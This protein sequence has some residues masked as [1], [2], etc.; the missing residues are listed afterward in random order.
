MAAR[1][2]AQQ[3]HQLQITPEQ[4]LLDPTA[5]DEFIRAHGTQFVHYRALRCPIGSVDR[6]DIRE[7]HE[8]HDDCSGGFI[9]KA[10]G[11][12]TSSFGGNSTQRDLE[13]IGSLDGSSV[14]I[15]VPRFYD[16]DPETVDPEI[17][18]HL[19]ES[20]RLYLK[21]PIAE[22]VMP[23]EGIE[24]HQTGIDRL[25]YPATAIELLVDANGIEYQEGQ[26]FELDSSNGSLRWLGSRRPGYDPERQR[27]T[28]FQVR[29]RYVP[30]W[31]VAKLMHEIRVTKA[32]SDYVT[33]KLKLYRMNYYALLQREKVYDV[34]N[35]PDLEILSDIR[36]I[37]GARDGSF[38]PR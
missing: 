19:A 4:E 30:F 15:T 34:E 20:D 28:I 31:Y 2:P 12:F 6:D 5:I 7:R 21:E 33:G 25:K 10:A 29:Y 23:W 13:V 9:Y 27:G 14:S 38:P 35:R 18:I 36:D 11:L 1:D 32:E 37:R 26:D 3:F 22:V 16:C 17:P 8:D 24:A